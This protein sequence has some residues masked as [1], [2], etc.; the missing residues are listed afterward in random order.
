[1]GLVR[2]EKEKR[3]ITA[4]TQHAVSAKLKV[5]VQWLNDPDIYRDGKNL[6]D[7]KA[8]KRYSQW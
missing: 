5:A 4:P 1:M 3:T 6:P 7:R 2:L 8:P